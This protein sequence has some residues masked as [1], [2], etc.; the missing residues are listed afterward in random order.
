MTDIH[1]HVLPGIDDGSK[2][3]AQSLDMLAET[4]AQGIHTIAAT[5]HFYPSENSPRRFLERRNAAAGRL[6]DALEDSG[7]PTPHI[8]LGAEVYYFDGIST[9]D[10]VEDLRIE[11]TQLLLLEMPFSPWTERMVTEVERLHER[12]GVTVLMAHIERYF[13]FRKAWMFDELLDCG[14]L[15]QSN[16]EFFLGWRTR[17]KALRM[18]ANN[19]IQFLGSDCHNM[20]S[21]APRLGE[22]MAVIG[23]EGCDQVE[24]NL[25]E[26]VPDLIYQSKTAQTV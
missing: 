23:P 6:F 25:R 5:S 21:R 10:E 24:A 12:R 20:F 8:L 17:R 19:E 2:N 11:G 1:S 18:L 9:A 15:M 14:V 13:R 7:T 3:V 22:A 4:A 26:W 16:A